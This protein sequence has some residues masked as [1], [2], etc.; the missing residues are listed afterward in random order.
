MSEKVQCGSPA[1]FRYTWPGQDEK[2]CCLAHAIQLLTL[3][4]AMMLYLQLILLSPE[5]SEKNTCSQMV[6]EEEANG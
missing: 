6:K 3:A 2:H 1:I 4:E 5:E